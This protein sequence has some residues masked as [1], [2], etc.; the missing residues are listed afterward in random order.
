LIELTQTLIDDIK[1]LIGKAGAENP[2]PKRDMPDK[3]VLARMLEAC[4]NFDMDVVY[5][6]IKELESYAYETDGDLVPWLYENIQQFNIDEVI[7]R[8]EQY[9]GENNKTY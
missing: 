2:K 4:G 5:A 9:T 1:N 6:A 7:E 3:E 8:L